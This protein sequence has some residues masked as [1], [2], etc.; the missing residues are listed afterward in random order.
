MDAYKSSDWNED[1]V[2]AMNDFLFEKVLSVNSNAPD[3]L[4]YHLIDIFYPEIE[5]IVDVKVC[6]LNE[7][8]ACPAVI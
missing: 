8:P 2:T 7:K 4:K 6:L 1:D 3:G 5:K